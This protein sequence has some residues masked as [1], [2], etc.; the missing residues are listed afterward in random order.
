MT[1]WGGE[2]QGKGLSAASPPQVRLL[3]RPALSVRDSL[4]TS[5]GPSQCVSGYSTRAGSV[6]M[7]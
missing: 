4:S 3:E 7:P 6:A 1:G 5:T 2:F